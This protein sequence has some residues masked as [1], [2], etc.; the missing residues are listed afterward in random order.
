MKKHRIPT[1]KSAS[2]SKHQLE[3]ALTFLES[4]KAPYV[5]KDGLA[6]GKGVI[7]ESD[8]A[9]AKKALTNMLNGQ[10]GKASGTVV[11]EEFLTGVELMLYHDGKI[12]NFT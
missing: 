12:K 8:L 7:I 9:K 3:D 4:Q 10:F 2:F 6:A 11:I 1:A 5:L